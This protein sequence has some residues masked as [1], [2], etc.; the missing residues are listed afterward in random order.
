MTIIR[1]ERAGPQGLA[2]IDKYEEV[3]TYL[4]PIL[5]RFPRAHGKA[6]DAIMDA[7]FDQVGLFYQAAKSRQPSRLYAADANL[8]TLRFWLRFASNPKLKLISPG[9]HRTALRL[10]AEVGGMLGAWIRG[11]K[12]NG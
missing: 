5:Q 6:R 7:L 4:Y 10:L 12:G 9:Q 2:I 3:V 11:T 8:A 1:D